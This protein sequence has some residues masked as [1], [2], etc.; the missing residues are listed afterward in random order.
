MPV[1]TNRR[2]STYKGIY[3]EDK[4]SVQV[5]LVCLDIETIFLNTMLPL[6]QFFLLLFANTINCI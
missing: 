5:K 4:G 2:L 6:M 1:N 3:I